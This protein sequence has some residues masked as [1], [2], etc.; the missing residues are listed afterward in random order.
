MFVVDREHACVASESCRIF[1]RDQSAH[2]LHWKT[3]ITRCDKSRF[4]RYW[5][6]SGLKNLD[7]PKIFIKKN[8]RNHAYHQFYPVLAKIRINRIR[9]NRGLLYFSLFAIESAHHVML[10]LWIGLKNVRVFCLKV[11]IGPLAVTRLE[12]MLNCHISSI[13]MAAR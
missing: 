8:E 10:F 9:I 11:S 6:R 4:F 3:R 5:Q 7:K 1:P 2:L 13:V 12:K